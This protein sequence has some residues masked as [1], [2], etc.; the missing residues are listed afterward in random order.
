MQLHVL[1]SLLLKVRNANLYYGFP[2]S[3]T[4]FLQSLSKRRILQLLLSV[5]I[6]SP[7]E[8]FACLHR[9]K[10]L[11]NLHATVNPTYHFSVKCS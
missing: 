10:W 1:A 3:A 7:N 5:V 6:Q 11:H 9:K 4:R 8:D 2:L